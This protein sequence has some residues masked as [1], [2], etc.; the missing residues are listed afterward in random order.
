MRSQALCSRNDSDLCPADSCCT[1]TASPGGNVGLGPRRANT[2]SQQAK[3]RSRTAKTVAYPS[4]I[5]VSIFTPL[6]SAE[7]STVRAFWALFV[8]GGAFKA[9]SKIQALQR[10]ATLVCASLLVTK[11]LLSHIEDRACLCP[12]VLLLGSL[13]HASCV[14]LST[15]H[16][17]MRRC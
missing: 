6:G 10:S 14:P 1:S 12:W 16:E 7:A 2:E 5:R 15:P 17:P 3:R 4:N 9:G 11:C 8:L 13:S